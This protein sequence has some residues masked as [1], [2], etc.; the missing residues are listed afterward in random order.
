M[1]PDPLSGC[2]G[3]HGS[4]FWAL[5]GESSDEEEEEVATECEISIEKVDGSLRETELKLGVLNSTDPEQSKEIDNALSG[6][7]GTAKS[8]K[9]SKVRPWR[10]P[11]P[12]RRV[13]PAMALGEFAVKDLRSIGGRSR[14]RCLREVLELGQTQ[15]CEEDGSP[16]L[17]GETAEHQFTEEEEEFFESP[18]FAGNEPSRSNGP[19][20][21]WA[22]HVGYIQVGAHPIFRC[23]AGL[24]FLFKRGGSF[25]GRSRA[26]APQQKTFRRPE[27]FASTRERQAEE[28]SDV[29]WRGGG[30]RDGGGR[31]QHG[32]RWL[33]RGGFGGGGG[34][35][36]REPYKAEW[37]EGRQGTGGFLSEARRTHAPGGGRFQGH[38]GGGGGFRGRGA[39]GGGGRGLGAAAERVLLK[40]TKIS[41]S[42][43][44]EKLIGKR[45]KVTKKRQTVQCK[46]LRKM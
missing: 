32:G 16:V 7:I 30:S 31:G 12:Q 42:K 4:R 45:R 8:W 10:G 35:A 2:R 11:L 39:F 5:A 21:E 22:G 14:G 19:V 3:G 40:E 27:A 17:G 38:A 34:R 43:S 1:S 23:S 13:T 36:C 28:K 25:K 41:M 9:P 6:G 44:S 29:M 37:S 18:G 24:S 26:L 20:V 33:P 15:R 46:A